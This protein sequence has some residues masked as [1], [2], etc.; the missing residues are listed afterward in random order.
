MFRTLDDEWKRRTRQFPTVATGKFFLW[1]SE[2]DA[3]YLVTFH[4]T[5]Y[6]FLATELSQ[7]HTYKDAF[8]SQWVEEIAS[9]PHILTQLRAECYPI[10]T[11]QHQN[12]CVGATP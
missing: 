10:V 3:L 7:Q 9:D 5:L 1:R 11:Q 8:Q 2:T 6:Q 12:S 4:P